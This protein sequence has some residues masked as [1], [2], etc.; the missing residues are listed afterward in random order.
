[1]DYYLLNIKDNKIISVN[2][3]NVLDKLYYF[4]CTIPTE[5]DIEKN[6]KIFGKGKSKNILNELKKNI[7]QI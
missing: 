5:K 6:I 4:E 3:N 1:M 2:I 7:S